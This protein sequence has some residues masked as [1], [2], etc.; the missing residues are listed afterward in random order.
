VSGVLGFFVVAMGMLLMLGAV[1]LGLFVAGGVVLWAL[2]RGR[3]PP[4]VNLR[5][6]QRMPY[7]GGFGRPGGKVVG[8]VVDVQAR[9]LDEP[10]PRR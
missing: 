6:G 7:G 1:V 4:A 5:W 10:G 3:R 9:E 2:L 8:E